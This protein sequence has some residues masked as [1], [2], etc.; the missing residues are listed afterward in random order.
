METDLV[1]T[2]SHWGARL[3]HAAWQ[4]RIY[5]RGGK[6]KKYPDFAVCRYGE[7]D[8]LCGA[9]C[10]HTFYPFFE[11]ISTPNKQEKEPEPIE[12]KGKTYTYTEATQK[13]RQMERNIRATKR[14]IEATKAMNGDTGIL[15][16][17]KT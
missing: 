10:R 7:V 15:E 14:E 3:E 13:Q 1:E 17:K 2:Y 4:G 11:G 9:N 5:S 16:A 12:Y 6:S 8:G